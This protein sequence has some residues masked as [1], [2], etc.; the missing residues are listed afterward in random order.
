M[1]VCVGLLTLVMMSHAANADE[2]R[3]VT[4][5][6]VLAVKIHGGIWTRTVDLGK[7]LPVRECGIRMQGAVYCR[8]DTGARPPVYVRT[9]DRSGREYTAFWGQSCR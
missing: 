3:R 1:R 2:C 7:T 5:P 8:L 6:T 9:I 4:T